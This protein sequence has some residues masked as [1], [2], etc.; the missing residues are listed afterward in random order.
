MV[1]WRFGRTES[2]YPR[3][4]GLGLSWGVL[5][6]ASG[7]ASGGSLRRVDYPSRCYPYHLQDFCSAAPVG[8]QGISFPLVGLFCRSVASLY[9]FCPVFGMGWGD[10]SEG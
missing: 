9:L 10:F 4:E 3:G 8:V 1:P 2:R 5:H 6:G 7:R